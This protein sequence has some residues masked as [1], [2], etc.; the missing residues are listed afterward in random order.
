MSVIS[1]FIFMLRFEY[2]G[3]QSGV[4]VNKEKSYCQNTER[5]VYYWTFGI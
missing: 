1:I 3:K 2:L 4:T 5:L